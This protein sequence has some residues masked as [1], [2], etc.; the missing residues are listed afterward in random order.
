M[1]LRS[2]MRALTQHKLPRGGLF[3]Q[4]LLCLRIGKLNIVRRLLLWQL[5]GRAPAAGQETGFSCGYTF[6]Q[7]SQR[8]RHSRCRRRHTGPSLFGVRR[9]IP[10]SQARQS[11]ATGS[12]A[13]NSAATT[14]IGRSTAA[15][16]ANAASDWL[17]RRV[18]GSTITCSTKAAARC[19]A[20]LT[21][22][23]AGPVRTTPTMFGRC[24][25]AQS[26]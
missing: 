12:A 25:Q 8:S 4:I 6:F 23:C 14:V 24:R 17:Y 18:P 5:G 19:T 21:H 15:D 22:A 7:F 10:S 13:G 2:L 3:T 11:V 1:Y 16:T 26:P 9:S 20:V